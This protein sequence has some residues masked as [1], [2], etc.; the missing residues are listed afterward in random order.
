MVIVIKSFYGDDSSVC[1]NIDGIYTVTVPAENNGNYK[2][3]ISE[4]GV[5]LDSIR[6]YFVESPED[7]VYDEFGMFTLDKVKELWPRFEAEIEEGTS[8]ASILNILG[9]EYKETRPTE[10]FDADFNEFK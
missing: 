2:R 4:T 6:N 5:I 7:I 1:Q 3:L 9:W 10:L 8:L